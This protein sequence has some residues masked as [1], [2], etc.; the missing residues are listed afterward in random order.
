[1]LMTVISRNSWRLLPVMRPYLSP[2]WDKMRE[3]SPIWLNEK[4]VKIAV[5]RDKPVMDTARLESM[6]F[7]ARMPKVI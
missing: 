3:N 2:A 6:A 4:P 1:M 7:M 5:R